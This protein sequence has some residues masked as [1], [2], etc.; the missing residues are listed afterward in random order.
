MSLRQTSK[1]CHQASFWNCKDATFGINEFP[2]SA[3]QMKRITNLVSREKAL[4]TKLKNT[5]GHRVQIGKI[6]LTNSVSLHCL[7]WKALL[8]VRYLAAKSK[9]YVFFVGLFTLNISN[10]ILESLVKFVMVRI[11]KTPYS[12]SHSLIKLVSLWIPK[13]GYQFMTKW[14]KTSFRKVHFPVNTL[15]PLK[16]LAK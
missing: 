11:I 12:T 3:V 15:F 9:V 7:Q 13:Y 10:L 14:L 16:R 8:Y 4:E 2:R 1:T 6:V 5:Q